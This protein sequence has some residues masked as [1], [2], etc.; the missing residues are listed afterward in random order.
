MSRQAFSATLTRESTHDD[1]LSVLICCAFAQV[2][3]SFGA[4]RRGETQ[5]LADDSSDAI[6]RLLVDIMCII[7]QLWWVA[8]G[9]RKMG[10]C[11]IPKGAILWSEPGCRKLSHA[12]EVTNCRH[13]VAQSEFTV[14]R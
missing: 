13:S 6:R 9:A 2:T 11:P 4:A 1:R 7:G 8:D 10:A 3:A 5:I 12:R 14:E